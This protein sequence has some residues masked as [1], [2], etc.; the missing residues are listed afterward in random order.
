MWIPEIIDTY[1]AIRE[2]II[3]TTPHRVSIIYCHNR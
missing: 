1:F 2:K 3:I